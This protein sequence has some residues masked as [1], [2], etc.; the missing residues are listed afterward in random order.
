VIIC[1]CNVLSMYNC[2]VC[3]SKNGTIFINQFIE[4]S[5]FKH[6]PLLVLQDISDHNY[7]MV[8]LYFKLSITATVFKNL[9]YL[10]PEP[11]KEADDKNGSDNVDHGARAEACHEF[12]RGVAH[13]H[14]GVE[15]FLTQSV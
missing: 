12:G 3:L 13:H 10:H 4:F 5:I 2:T 15:I 6:C 11:G 8:I 14:A 9:H 1:N 7:I